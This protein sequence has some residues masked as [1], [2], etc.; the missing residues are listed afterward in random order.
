MMVNT[1]ADVLPPG[2]AA[3]L[4]SPVQQGTTKPE[5]VS[6]W[7]HMTE[8]NP[9]ECYTYNTARLQDLHVVII[10]FLDFMIYC[11]FLYFIF[12][13]CNDCIYW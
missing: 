4:I 3:V 5:C 10:Y 13:V 11:G 12:A 9:G 8:G 6:F 1:D 2:S 7:Y